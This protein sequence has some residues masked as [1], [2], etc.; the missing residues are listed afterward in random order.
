M[1]EDY[2]TY[3]FTLL[4]VT[5]SELNRLCMKK[6]IDKTEIKAHLMKQLGFEDSVATKLMEK[7]DKSQLY[8]HLPLFG[9]LA[10]TL[11]SVVPEYAGTGT[12]PPGGIDKEL[13]DR[14]T[15]R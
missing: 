13:V 7:L 8:F 2:N 4:L 11:Q 14:I 1:A 3:A 15:K 9:A 10:Q 12:H 5:P 6:P